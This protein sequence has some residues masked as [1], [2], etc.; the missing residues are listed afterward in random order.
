MLRSVNHE[1][2]KAKVEEPEIRKIKE[3]SVG[4]LTLD[5][6]LPKYSKWVTSQI[7]FIKDRGIRDAQ[8]KE[9]IWKRIYPQK[10]GIPIYNPHGKYWVKLHHMGEERLVEIDDKMPCDAKGHIMLPHS[11]H[12]F[13]IWPT[14]LTKAILKLYSY[15]WRYKDNS[16]SEVGD[17]SIVH[18]LTGLL[19]EKVD[20]SNFQT[21]KWHLLKKL[22]SDDHYFNKKTYVCGYCMA[23]YNP[24]LPSIAKYIKPDEKGGVESSSND[25]NTAPAS[26]GSKTLLKLKKYANIALSVTSGKKVKEANKE[27][28]TN[29]VKGFGYA[30]MDYFENEG[31]DMLYALKEDR[32]TIAEKTSQY[33]PEKRKKRRAIGNDEGKKKGKDSDTISRKS[34]RMGKKPVR[35]FQFLKVK[36][37][38]GKIPIVNAVCPFTNDEISTAKKCML[39]KWEKPPDYDKRKMKYEQE[40]KKVGGTTDPKD[41]FYS[42]DKVD[43]DDKYESEDT[44]KEPDADAL[45]E[46]KEEDKQEPACTEPKMRAP[47]GLWMEAAD[48]A[49][50]FQYLLIFHNPRSYSSKVCYK[51]LWSNANESFVPNE[52]KIYIVLKPG[53]AEEEKNVIS[54]EFKDLP[55]DKEHESSKVLVMFAPNGCLCKENEFATYYSCT[56]QPGLNVKLTNYMMSKLINVKDI[57]GQL[58][59]QPNIVAPFGYTLW[60]MSNYSVSKVSE[61]DYLCTRE[62]PYAKK[63]AEVET[64][65]MRQGRYYVIFRYNF[66][67]KEEKTAC[68]LKL[69]LADKY[70]LECMRFHVIN[71]TQKNVPEGKIKDA[72]IVETERLSVQNNVPFTL[73]AGSY[74]LVCDM[75]AP[76][77]IDA[78]KVGVMLATLPDIHEFAGIELE[79]QAE[80]GDVYTPYK[81][82]VIFRE[83]IFVDNEIPV[84]L[85]VRLRKGGFAKAAVQQKDDKKGGRKEV[86]EKLTVVPEKD[87]DPPRKIK[88][89]IME[90]GE[91]LYSKTGYNHISIPHLK[92]RKTVPGEHGKLKNSYIVQ[93]GFDIS[94]WPSCVHKNEDTQDIGW[95]IKVISPS[96]VA[97][98]KD[99]EKADK[100]EGIKESWEE[101]EP[102]RAEK[103]KQSRARFLA[104]KKKMKGEALTEQEQELIRDAGTHKKEDD[105]KRAPVGQI[106]KSQPTKEVKK[107]MAGKG[108]PAKHEEEV[109]Q[110]V[111]DLEK[112]LPEPQAHINQE[113]QEYLEH[114]KSERLIIV[115]DK[116]YKAKTRTA[117]EI[118]QIKE[119]HEAEM[120]NFEK[121]YKEKKTQ[122]ENDKKVREETKAKV[123]QGLSTEL[124][125]NAEGFKDLLKKRGEYKEVLV[126]RKAKEDELIRMIAQDKINIEVRIYSAN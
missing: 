33:S 124:S 110:A 120:Q 111:L 13:E 16:E 126:N 39:N 60:V 71:R 29:V 12:P 103:G 48:L 116:N 24:T 86:D 113:I 92:L 123:Q 32:D 82:G 109:G 95:A 10:D 63:E 91:I 36:S 4:N 25:P 62:K 53:N 8:T 54:E 22:L 49:H 40:M 104:L 68:I 58:A 50:C 61:L 97:I 31:F 96:S 55:V 20:L 79:E 67:C 106:R 7:Q 30:L 26:G 52:D 85:H 23:D 114:A 17:A 42:N 2:G 73:A 89:E 112:P 43:K 66:T 14:L 101:A 65:Q 59:V 51:D 84:S 5:T 76:Y 46:D 100:E 27:R 28:P 119:K 78:T 57:N 45:K 118:D 83:K 121:Y 108:I 41:S 35:K 94:D 34:S 18:S 122:D 98:V 9:P 117:I 80:Y 56:I 69:K 125:E 3:V 15:Q 74:S 38:V 88:V 47:G 70:L 102:G 1:L 107:Q 90:S 37:S 19:P 21:E 115:P 6:L 99:T 72:E 87:L 77:N 93:C 105:S 75:L 81:Y 44:K 11:E 64:P